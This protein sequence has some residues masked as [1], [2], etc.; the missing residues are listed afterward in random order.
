MINHTDPQ[1]AF[2]DEYQN[3]MTLRDYFAAK[4]LQERKN[5]PPKKRM[6]MVTKPLGNAN[7]SGVNCR[8]T[9]T[10]ATYQT[11]PPVQ[12]GVPHRHRCL[13]RGTD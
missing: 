9:Y 10:S 1:A 8:G 2:P 13:Q 7:A 5:E 6:G 12:H 4:A 11:A 3:G